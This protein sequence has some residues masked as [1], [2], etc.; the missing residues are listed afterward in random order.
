MLS[1]RAVTGIC[2]SRGRG[3]APPVVLEAAAAQVRCAARPT[4]QEPHCSRVGGVRSHAMT[5]VTPDA[6]KAHALLMADIRASFWVA[7]STAR[8]AWRPPKSMQTSQRTAPTWRLDQTMKAISASST[9]AVTQE[10]HFISA[11]YA[12]APTR[13]S[14]ARLRVA[15]RLLNRTVPST[16]VFIGSAF[17]AQYPRGG[18]MFWIPLQY[19]RGLRE[20]GHDA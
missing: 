13:S 16:S 14:G 11:C 2:G 10:V 5:C 18:G 20:L 7:P 12:T 4:G 17:V 19:L 1:N 15:S 9:P 6:R 3:T 8:Q